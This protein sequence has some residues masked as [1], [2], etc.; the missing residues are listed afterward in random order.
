MDPRLVPDPGFVI[1]TWTDDQDCTKV[2]INVCSIRPM[3]WALGKAPS[4]SAADEHGGLY[5]SKEEA[6]KA[7]QDSSDWCILSKKIFLDRDRKGA[8]CRVIQCGIDRMILDASR[9]D[10]RFKMVL[11]ASILFQVIESCN[12]NVPQ[13]LER[14]KLPRMKSK[15][16]IPSITDW[17]TSIPIYQ[18]GD[19]QDEALED[20]HIESISL[21]E[22]E[23]EASMLVEGKSKRLDG[24][25]REGTS[26]NVRYNGVPAYS[27]SISVHDL[28]S[29]GEST[30]SNMPK[31]YTKGSKVHVQSSCMAQPLWIETNLMLNGKDCMQANFAADTGTLLLEI[32]VISF[33]TYVGMCS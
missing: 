5:C 14:I 17:G 33:S 12:V 28:R 18:Q 21:Y 25:Q 31:V 26:F 10:K 30:E 15:G 1:K 19:Q 9:E 7:V 13:D 20:K 23:D 4:I 27:V 3:G 11:T 2:F 24:R 16:N 6:M 29:K 22:Q 8:A 32:P